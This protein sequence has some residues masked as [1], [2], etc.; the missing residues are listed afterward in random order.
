M[1]SLLLRTRKSLATATRPLAAGFALLALAACQPTAGP[2][3][4]AASGTGGPVTVAL[5]VPAGSATP[6]DDILAR[7]LENA[8]RMAIADLGGSVQVTLNVYPTGG[9]PA[10]A[11]NAAQTAVAEGAQIIL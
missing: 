3:T 4:S 7:D 8:A 10:Q 11:A 5:L 1:L 2:T 9:Q 6:G